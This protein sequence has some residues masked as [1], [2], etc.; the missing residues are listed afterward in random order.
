[1]APSFDPRARRPPP[2]PPP[3]PPRPP[4]SASP[5]TPLYPLDDTAYPPHQDYASYYPAYPQPPPTTSTSPLRPPPPPPP[6]A[7]PAVFHRQTPSWE[8]SAFISSYA[9]QPA[10]PQALAHPPYP[11]YA[12]TPVQPRRQESLQGSTHHSTHAR[13]R[14]SHDSSASSSHFSVYSLPPSDPAQSPPPAHSNSSRLEQQQAAAAAASD[15][16]HR[17]ESLHLTAASEPAYAARPAPPQPPL[18][19]QESAPPR[20]QPTILMSPPIQQGVP[21]YL[22][23]THS[24]DTS[25][26][27]S[28]PRPSP[29]PSSTL[30]SSSSAGSGWG[31]TSSHPTTTA[32]STSSPDVSRRPS[33]A[34]YA[35]LT[36][37]VHAS[38]QFPGAGTASSASLRSNSYDTLPY[39]HDRS[40]S[41]GAPTASSSWASFPS[42]FPAPAPPPVDAWDDAHLGSGGGVSAYLDPSLLSHLAVFLA[43]HVHEHASLSSSSAG[44]GDAFSGET[45]ISTLVRALPSSTPRP[46]QVAQRVAESLLAQLWIHDPHWGAGGDG[47]WRAGGAGVRDDDSQRFVLAREGP[48][49]DDIAVPSGV[50]VEAARCYS[51]FCERFERERALEGGEGE[52]AGGPSGAG[53]GCYAYDCPNRKPALHRLASTLSTTTAASPSSAAFL[54]SISPAPST[55]T[56]AAVAP[57]QPE[58]DNWATSVPSEVRDAL[59]K[60]EIAYQNQVFELVQ[61]EQKYYDDLCLIETAF[62]E[63][64]RTA[65][66]PIIAP[67]SRLAHFLSTVLLNLS[68]IRDHSRTLLAALRHRQAEHY[69]FRG[70]GALVLD[71]ALE[72]ERDYVAFTIEFP[73]ADFLLKE[74]RDRN[75]RFAE[76]LA[77][78]SRRPEAA[79]R[80]FD[81]F[82]NRATFRG[83]RYVLLLEQ[84]LASSAPD[85]PDR[86]YLEQALDVIRRQGSLANEGIERTKERVRLREYHRDLVKKGGD[87]PDLELVDER[88]RLLFA[89]RVFRRPEASGPA[90]TDQFAEAHVALF[91]NYLVVTKPPRALDRDGSGHAKYQLARRPVPID[92]VQLRTTSFSDPPVP[93]SSGFH[94]RSTRSTGASVGGGSGFASGGL[95]PGAAAGMAGS[96]AAADGGAPLSPV[97]STTGSFAT[98]MAGTGGGGGGGGG[99]SPSPGLASGSS[100]AA[101]DSLLWPISFF[102]LGRYD[103]LVHLYVESAALRAQWEAHLHA[104]VA[105]RAQYAAANPVVR[106]DPLA[107]LTFGSTSAVVGSLL[108]PAAA[109][110]DPGTRFGKPTCSTPLRMPAAAGS[111]SVDGHQWLVVA[112]CAEGIFVGWRAGGA[113]SAAV[114]GQGRPQ[115]RTMQQVVHLEGITQCAVLPEFSFLLVIANKVLVAYALEALIPSKAGSKLDQA[116]K[117]P[118]RLSGQKDVSFFKVGKIGDADPRTLVIYAKKSGVKESVFKALEPVSNAERA[119]GGGGGGHRFLGLGG[120][121]PEWFRTYKEFFMPSLVTGL[122][123]QRSKLALI[124][125]RG[126]E[127]MDLESMRTMTVPDFPPSRHDRALYLLAKRCEDAATMGMF[128]IGDSK[129]LL[130]YSEFA[131]HVGRHGEPIE[132]PFIE[133]ESKPETI[134]YCAPYIFAISP[135]IVEIRN[136]FSGRLAQF[137]TGTHISLTYDGTAIPSSPSTASA[138]PSPSLTGS[139]RSSFDPSGTAGGAGA[140]EDDL[141]GPVER[142]LHLTMKQGAYHI[143]SEV[144]IVA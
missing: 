123:F 9:N 48:L 65:S 80:G 58:A 59:D 102:Q 96:A 121:R 33:Y 84:I 43:D 41:G 144:V 75:P 53:A 64:L 76:L 108:S 42:S 47:D 142:R 12:P 114:A 49:G 51:P 79:R 45:A 116:S 8:E 143:L 81:T 28:H 136:A 70:V 93:R 66:P 130:A 54:T 124:G 69:L 1:M 141:A 97:P 131:I 113:G 83:L 62:V 63:P 31:S 104:A 37:P 125:S 20:R 107:D 55:A 109:R 133:W 105:Q 14:T 120:G 44:P 82:H 32:T 128:R 106:L 73:M 6:G 11:A 117:A 21:D 127:I 23:R 46:R 77:D 88:R 3:R 38:A 24:V 90:F 29:S 39:H 4:A 99:G 91:D 27:Y 100:A 87:M 60:R 94:L 40:V 68:A 10:S 57:P 112:G 95:P 71:A 103:G 52:R 129:F 140:G 18:P 17:L 126:V 119:R 50:V 132:G 34:T 2:P 134:A 26:T 19:R 7:Q 56:S 122:H 72:W 35:T 101:S 138:S 67:A 118:Q 110:A 30:P 115:Q 78:F 36:P 15:Y 139:R 89:G 92:L 22:S 16:R 61:G 85:D 13:S 137:I 25:S 111:G 135:T 74:E 86:P 98:S 5:A